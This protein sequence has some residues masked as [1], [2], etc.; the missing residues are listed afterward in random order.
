M[1]PLASFC[2]LFSAILVGPAQPVKTTA[3]AHSVAMANMRRS[4]STSMWDL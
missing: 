3:I 2:W 1:S 4:M